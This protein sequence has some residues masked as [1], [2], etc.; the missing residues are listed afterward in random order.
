MTFGSQARAFGKSIGWATLVGAAIPLAFTSLL[1]LF[2]L[3]DVFSGQMM[4]WQTLY[5]ASLPILVTF[6]IVLLSCLVLGLP[7]T[8]ILRRLG[9]ESLPAYAGIGAMFGLLIPILGLHLIDAPAGYWT[10][11]LGAISGATAGYVWWHES[12][13]PPLEEE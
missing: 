12:R 11:F 4:I 1:A 5:L 2:S 3:Q 13:V 6:P 8:L 10:A 7:L 9:R